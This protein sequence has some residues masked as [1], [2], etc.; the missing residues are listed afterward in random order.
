MGNHFIVRNKAHFQTSRWSGGSTTELYLYPEDGSYKEGNFQCRIS[1]AVVEVEQ[2]EFTSLPGVKRYL[3]I[4]EGNLEMIHG[5]TEKVRLKPYEVDCFDGGT[6]TVSF[7]QVTDF[8]LMLKNGAEGKMETACLKKGEKISLKPENGEQ[9]LAVY[10]KCGG[11]KTEGSVAL[12][13]ELLLCRDWREEVV[14]EN[15][16]DCKAGLGICRVRV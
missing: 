1:S 15:T 10:V 12:A 2:S 3:S 7:G 4:F 11:V 6:S 9:I 16:G 8:N 5:E 13:W 14:L